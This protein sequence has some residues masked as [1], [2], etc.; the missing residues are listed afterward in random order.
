[1]EKNQDDL[2]NLQKNAPPTPPAAHGLMESGA[3]DLKVYVRGNPAKP[4]ETAP[5]RFL[6]VLAGDAP[7]PFAKGSGRLELAECVTAK[8]NPLTARVFVNRVW[9]WHF[10]RGIVGTPSNFGHLGEA[11]THPQLLDYLAARFVESG[12]SIKSLHREIMLSATYQR[13]CE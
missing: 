3:A 7:R 12:G 5:R 9:A 13:S 4:G 1:I 8:D 11:P 2:K 10:G 6:R